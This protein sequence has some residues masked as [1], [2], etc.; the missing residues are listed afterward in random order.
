MDVYIDLYGE[1]AGQNCFK[2]LAHVTMGAGKGEICR[3]SQ[4][5]T[6]AWK[7]WCCRRES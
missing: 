3:A 1:K 7:S 2:E 6:D 4:Q 5:A